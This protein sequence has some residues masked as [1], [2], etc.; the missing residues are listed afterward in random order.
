[1]NRPKWARRFY[2]V[3]TITCNDHANIFFVN[4]HDMVEGFRR[5]WRGNDPYE[6]QCETYLITYCTP[7]TTHKYVK[8]TTAFR[9][10]VFARFFYNIKLLI[11]W[12]RV[13]GSN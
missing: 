3:Q 10:P 8:C 2:D 11:A 9:E 5:L 12:V 13:G 7:T 6:I 4:K 1:M